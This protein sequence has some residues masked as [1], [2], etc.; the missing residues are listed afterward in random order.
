M[1]IPATVSINGYKFKVTGISQNAFAKN[2]KV[3]SVTI[4]KNVTS[5]GSNAFLNCSSLKSMQIKGTSIKKVG[6]NAFKGVGKNAVIRVPKKARRSYAA[7][8]KKAGFGGTV[9]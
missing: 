6:K 2:K 8:L 4:D 7:K 5:I 1:K 9:K 3:K